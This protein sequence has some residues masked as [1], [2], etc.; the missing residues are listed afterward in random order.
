MR[1]DARCMLGLRRG[2]GGGEY[3]DGYVSD[4]CLAMH[5]GT[6]IADCVGM[7]IPAAIVPAVDEG[8]EGGKSGDM[9]LIAAVFVPERI[10]K[11]CKE[12]IVHIHKTNWP[13]LQSLFDALINIPQNVLVANRLAAFFASILSSSGSSATLFKLDPPVP[14]LFRPPSSPFTPSSSLADAGNPPLTL[15]S[16]AS[17]LR[18]TP[19]HASPRGP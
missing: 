9:I 10:D 13:K 8:T 2:G 4:V 7:V 17:G 6:V 3:D 19:L 1:M 16:S 11:R 15:R 14:A 12:F 18:G 5:R